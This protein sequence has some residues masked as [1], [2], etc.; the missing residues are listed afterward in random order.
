MWRLL[1]GVPPPNK[2]KT[3]ETIKEKD[4]EYEQTTRVRKFQD[5]WKIGRTWPTYS[6]ADNKMFCDICK[7][8]IVT[9]RNIITKSTGSQS[10][11]SVF[12]T[13][14]SNVKLENIKVHN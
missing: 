14:S 2:A 11:L 1:D 10:M 12:V 3:D 13:R 7:R 8:H 4:T 6:K 9:S 5:I